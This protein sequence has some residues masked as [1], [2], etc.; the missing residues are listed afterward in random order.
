MAGPAAKHASE[1]QKHANRDGEQNDVEKS[2]ADVHSLEKT[3]ELRPPPQV[4]R[5]RAGGDPA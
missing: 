3:D 1:L 5:E 4:A 2:Q